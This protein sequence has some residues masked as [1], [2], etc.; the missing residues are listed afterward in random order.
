ML[1][2]ELIT[3]IK[4][5]FPDWL[6]E[7]IE[8]LSGDE[9]IAFLA[10]VFERVSE[11]RKLAAAARLLRDATGPVK[12]SGTVTVNFASGTSGSGGFTLSAPR[13][14]RTAWGVRFR[15]VGTFARANGAGGGDVGLDLE[16]EFAG[17]DGNVEAER[18]DWDLDGV[19]WTGVSADAKAEF[20]AGVA[21]GSI[22]FTATDMTGG[23]AGTLDLKAQGK[24]MPRAPG[25][26]DVSLRKRLR[27]SPDAVTPAGIL[28]AVNKALGY[29]GATL[30]E[31]WETGFAMGVDAMGDAALAPF[32]SF[33]VTVPAGSDVVALQELV[34][35]I[36]GAGYRGTVMEAS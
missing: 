29:D 17:W 21:D 4:R 9:V 5:R 2:A 28:R 18:L 7:S 33:I 26:S 13:L 8:G 20:L 11:R 15:V 34:N 3:R 30:T 35:R 24:G 14:F 22:T 6:I 32:K 36:K 27:A 31:Y 16:A 12:A 23:R 25:E 19:D 10:A 1:R